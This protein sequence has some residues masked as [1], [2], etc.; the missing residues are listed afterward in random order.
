MTVGRIPPDLERGR[1]RRPSR[2]PLASQNILTFCGETGWGSRSKGVG[3]GEG[4]RARGGR[5][6]SP[7]EPRRYDDAPMRAGND[8]GWKGLVWRCLPSCAFRGE[9]APRG[10]VLQPLQKRLGQL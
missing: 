10:R 3:M 6:S 8:Q 2:Q 9:G 1:S 5:M 4:W 7:N